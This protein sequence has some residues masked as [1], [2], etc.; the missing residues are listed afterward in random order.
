MPRPL[1]PALLFALALSACTSTRTSSPTDPA[2]RAFLYAHADDVLTVRLAGGGS[3]PARSVRVEPDSASWVGAE[4][5]ALR[6]VA[7]AEVVSIERVDRGRGAV[8]GAVT[9]TATVGVTAAVATFVALR[10]SDCTPSLLSFCTVD[11]QAA[12]SLAVG[13]AAGF[14][15]AFPGAGVGALVGE[16]ERLALDPLAEGPGPSPGPTARNARLG[17]R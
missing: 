5:G 1:R 17:T 16:R 11:E 7:T 10:Q 15:A 3:E 12:L 14:L 9:A 2:A 6:R 13:S 8:R 4:T